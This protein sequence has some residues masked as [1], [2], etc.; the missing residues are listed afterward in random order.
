[1]GGQEK[2]RKGFLKK[3]MSWDLE[4]DKEREGESATKFFIS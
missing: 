3:R 1:M 4:K 2:E